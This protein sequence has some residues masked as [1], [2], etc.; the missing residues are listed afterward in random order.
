MKL[1]PDSNSQN[2][3]NKGLQYVVNIS[4][5][6]T[7][8]CFAIIVFK[9][10]MSDLDDWSFFRTDSP[11]IVNEICYNNPYVGDYVT[12]RDTAETVKRYIKN[13]RELNHL[14]TTAGIVITNEMLK[15]MS[16]ENNLL[17]PTYDIRGFHLYFADK[18]PNG[19]TPS[20]V[21]VPLGPGFVEF[22]PSHYRVLEVPEK[23]CAPCP[24]LCDGYE[25]T[26][27][28]P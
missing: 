1:I 28:G 16:V 12:N 27:I 7:V 25:L 14:D 19:E 26:Q 22:S 10:V 6:F 20:I 3:Y 5:T 15:A 18:S 23:A 24:L 9:V 21:F 11:I 17:R 4:V 8:A 13:Y 2:K